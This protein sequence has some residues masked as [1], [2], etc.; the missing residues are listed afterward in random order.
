[1]NSFPVEFMTEVQKVIE[2]IPIRISESRLVN[3]GSLN[4]LIHKNEYQIYLGS[5]KLTIPYRVYFDEPNIYREKNLTENESCILNCIY[6]RHGDGYIRQKRFGKLV[7]S[8]SRLVVP[9]AAQLLG[10]YLIS[11]LELIDE[12]VNESTINNYSKFAKENPKYWDTTKSRMVSYWD[13]YYRYKEPKL[14]K[15]IGSILINRIEQWNS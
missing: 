4:N 1:M 13:A 9:F 2:I 8:K 15:Y 7:S 14:K 5:D 11:I 12:H 10:E 3:N 6:S